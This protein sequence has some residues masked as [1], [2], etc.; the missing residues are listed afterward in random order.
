MIE[1]E[2]QPP[3]LPFQGVGVGVEARAGIEEQPHP[4]HLLFVAS[5]IL[6]LATK[7]WDEVVFGVAVAVAVHFPVKERGVS[8][9]IDH[10]H[11]YC[12]P[13]FHHHHQYHHVRNMFP[14][15]GDEVFLLKGALVA[16]EANSMILVEA[17]QATSP[18]NITSGLH[19][20]NTDMRL[21]VAATM[22]AKRVLVILPLLT[23]P[24]HL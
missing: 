19:K 1:S 9:E 13:R 15:V 11:P 22:T 5:V 18:P 7:V 8:A 12:L 2:T 20:K 23:L 4:H 3:P 6:L 17:I 21:A 24:Q 10:N 16:A 14:Q